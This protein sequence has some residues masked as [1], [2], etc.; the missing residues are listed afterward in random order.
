MHE[1]KMYE[2]NNLM[3]NNL[4]LNKMKNL[5]K[6]EELLLSMLDYH[7]QGCDKDAKIKNSK[8]R[9][10]KAVKEYGTGNA[11]SLL[12]ILKD[13]AKAEKKRSEYFQ[14]QES[15]KKE[16]DIIIGTLKFITP[17]T[18]KEAKE[19]ITFGNYKTF[20]GFAREY[21]M[22][23]KQQ[24]AFEN[25]HWHYKTGV[26]ENYYHFEY[27]KEIIVNVS[28]ESDWSV[29]S[30]R[31]KYP[32]YHYH[33]TLKIPTNYSFFSSG[34]KLVITKGTQI[35]MDGME[36]YWFE[37]SR[38]MELRV[39]EGFYVLNQLIPKSKTINA[40][41]DAQVKVAEKANDQRFLRKL[42]TLELLDH[43]MSA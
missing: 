24:K 39:I 7:C 2:D 21:Y 9:I 38:G 19:F 43:K 40:L 32:A 28:T 8:A 34:G 20:T 15:V 23:M 4:K 25:I 33:F 13:N 17:P 3:F 10:K 41:W 12:K 42:K 26:H 5:S 29:Y 11:N 27:C 31:T 6:K 18:L 36:V 30:K 1:I 16:V 14:K 22:K 35:N 37:Q